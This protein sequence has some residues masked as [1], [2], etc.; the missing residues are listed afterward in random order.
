MQVLSM[1]KKH[2]SIEGML[3]AIAASDKAKYVVP[4]NWRFEKARELFVSPDV[5]DKSDL[6]KFSWELPKEKELTDYLVERMS[7]DMGRVKRGIERLKACKKKGSQ[8]RL[9]TFFKVMPSPAGK[10]KAK[11]KGKGKTKGKLAG[12]KRSRNES[13]NTNSGQPNNKRAKTKK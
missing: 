12:K 11:G 6:P 2:G 1:I 7:F 9:D 8:K 4:D 10:A 13:G 5:T 3:Q